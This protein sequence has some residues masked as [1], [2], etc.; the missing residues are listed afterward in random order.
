MLAFRL[1]FP[2]SLV[3]ILG[4]QLRR[5]R[6]QYPKSKGKTKAEPPQ[7]S[8]NMIRS[9]R[10]QLSCLSVPTQH[11]EYNIIQSLCNMSPLTSSIQWKISRHGR[12]EGTDNHESKANRSRTKD[13][14]DIG[15]SGKNFKMTMINK[16]TTQEKMYNKD[17]KRE[18]VKG[19]PESLK[20][21]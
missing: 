18:D 9:I 19:E 7:Q 5:P 11:I 1:S 3:N 8:L 14:S 15:K 6:R 20:Y 21:M 2:G 10:L 13:D 4:T 12:L 17:E 16:L